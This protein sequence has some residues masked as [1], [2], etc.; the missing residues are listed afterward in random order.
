MAE[1]YTCSSD[2]G[3]ST[4]RITSRG[5]GDCTLELSWTKDEN[6]EWVANKVKLSKKALREGSSIKGIHKGMSQALAAIVEGIV[7]WLWNKLC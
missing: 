5:D 3:K 6:G 1:I 4:L 2:D 7:R